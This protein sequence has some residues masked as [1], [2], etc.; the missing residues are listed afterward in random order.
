MKEFKIGDKVLCNFGPYKGLRGKIIADP[1]SGM[2]GVQFSVG[3]GTHDCDGAGKPGH[4]WW[5]SVDL[6]SKVD[7]VKLENK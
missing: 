3:K 1:N 4:C 2:P 6:M 5:L 7:S